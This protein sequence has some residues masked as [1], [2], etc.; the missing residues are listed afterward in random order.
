MRIVFMG[1]PEFA[2]P[3]LQHLILNDYRV[4]AVYTQPDRPSG[5]GRRLAPQP[6]KTAAEAF[7]L[8]VLQPFSFKTAEAVAELAYFQP[9]VIV[10][11]AFGQILPQ[12]VLKL[13]KYGCLNLH[14]SL[15]P[16]HR[17]ASPVVAAILGGDEFTGVS[18]MLMDKGL[19][20]GPLLVRAQIPISDRDNTGSLSAKL[21]LIAAHLLQEVLSELP[22]RELKPQPQDEAKATYSGTITKDSGEIDWHQPAVAIWRR[23]RAFYPW[24]GAYTKWQGKRLKFIEA[25]SLPEMEVASI[26]QVVAVSGDSFGIQTGGGVLGVLQVQMEGKRVMAAAEFLRGQRKFI[27]TVLPS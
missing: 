7:N 24:P 6:L 25:V 11:A 1:T 14:P 8:P 23:V 2:V 4:V 5:R 17:G 3:S 13:P 22:R 19:D 27:G 18:I 15:L 9:D 26:G 21:S 12:P 10:V 16:R 20:T